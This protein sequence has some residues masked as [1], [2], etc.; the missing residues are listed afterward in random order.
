[1][2]R[3]PIIAGN[4]KMHKTVAQSLEFVDEIL[5]LTA[6]IKGVKVVLCPPFTALY[7]VGQRLQGTHIEMGAQNVFWADEGAYTGEIS[8]LM[9]KD[10]GSKYVIVR[11]S[12]RR[13][14]FKETDEDINQKLKSLLQ[15]GLWPILCVGET[16]EQRQAGNAQQV[17]KKQ[18]EDGLRGVE[19]TG[20]DL[21]VAYE[22]VWAIGTGVNA[23]SEDAQDMIGFIRQELAGKFSQEIAQRV[24]ILYGGSVKVN[25]IEEFMRQPDIDGALIGGASLQVESLAEI[26]RRAEGIING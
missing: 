18:L 5:P 14:Q 20:N 11:H 19:T 17:V 3:I 26:A 24:R 9:L 25:N 10:T 2:M 23:S 4:W 6:E 8:P 12:E 1:M 7:P 21:V 16:L 13:Q 15:A 22:P